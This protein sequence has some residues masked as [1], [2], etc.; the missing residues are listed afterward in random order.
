MLGADAGLG[1]R[2]LREADPHALWLDPVTGRCGAAGVRATT[3]ARLPG[4]SFARTGA[5]LAMTS[6]GGWRTFA[7]D[8]ERRTG[9]GLLLEEQRTNKVS[10][11]NID[12]AGTGGLTAGGGG[13]TPPGLSVVADPVALAAAGL[14]GLS[15]GGRVYRLDNSGGTAFAYLNFPGGSGTLTDHVGS[16]WVRGGS[17]RLATSLGASATGSVGF[18][19]SAHYRRI[20]TAAMPCPSPTTRLSITADAGQV[21][22]FTLFQFEEGAFATSPI[23]T[24]GASAT[25][26]GDQA[27]M[28]LAVGAGQDFTEHGEVAFTRDTGVAQTLGEG[29]DG[30]G[31]NGWRVHRTAAGLLRAAVTIAGVETEVGA[32]AKVGARTVRWGLVRSGDAYGL[33]VDGAPTGSATLPG[34]AALTALRIGARRTGAE[35]LNDTVRRMASEPFARSVG[36]LVARTA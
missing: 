4:G 35:A 36:W 15:P 25:R 13:S 32:V 27:A 12:P 28:M 5:A 26:G 19:A 21:V 3:L 22:W 6:D 31:Q 2:A 1:A 24:P 20:V 8:Q 10:V 34:M 23:L 16:A 7:G 29:H 14:D 11:H 18:G 30:S 17:G 33:V 9:R